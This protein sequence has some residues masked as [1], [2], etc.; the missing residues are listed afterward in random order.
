MKLK[1]PIKKY[2]LGRIV[3]GCPY[4]MPRNFNR[5][6]ISIRKN[7]IPMVRRAKDWTFN[8]FGNQYWI[9]IGWPIKI[10][11]HGL[12]WK[13]KY[14]TPRFEFAPGFYIYFFHWQFCVWTVSPIGRTDSYY[15]Q[16]LWLEKYCNNN[17]NKAKETW[18]C[19]DGDTKEST[20]DDNFFEI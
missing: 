3:H 17:Y 11:W 4:F 12:G 10:T 15:E 6:I 9:Q 7:S 20:W 18:T 16:K 14:D 1:K 2:Y 19:V 5:N 13:D 8:L